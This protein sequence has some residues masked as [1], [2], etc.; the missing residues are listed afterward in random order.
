MTQIEDIDITKYF[1]YYQMKIKNP[2]ATADG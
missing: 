2:S 1:C